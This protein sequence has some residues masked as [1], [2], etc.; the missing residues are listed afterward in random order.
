VVENRNNDK[1]SESTYLKLIVNNTRGLNTIDSHFKKSGIDRT[2]YNC[3]SISQLLFLLDTQTQMKSL[4]PQIFEPLTRNFSNIGVRDNP[5]IELSETYYMYWPAE[6]DKDSRN[7]WL[8]KFI[9]DI[10]NQVY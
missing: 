5:D 2:I 10:V 4:L 3:Y 6:K 1:Q 7:I 8:R 9:V